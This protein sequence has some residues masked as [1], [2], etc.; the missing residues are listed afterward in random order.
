MR[1]IIVCDELP[2]ARRLCSELSNCPAEIICVANLGELK[3]ACEPLFNMALISVAWAELVEYI[4][5]IRESPSGVNC[6]VFVASERLSN[7]PGLAGILPKLRAMP[8][9]HG[10]L[11][12]LARWLMTGG[13]EHEWRRNPRPL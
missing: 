6:S 4:R 11:V 8:C 1:L 2:A 3:L 9:P 5:T 12:K 13:K 10:D 7:G